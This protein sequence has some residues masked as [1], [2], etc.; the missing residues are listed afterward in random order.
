MLNDLGALA[1]AQRLFSSE[2][3]S[4][5]FTRLLLLDRIDL[6]LE[7]LVVNDSEFLRLFPE[8]LGKIAKRR[9]GVR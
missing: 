8:E 4:E 6:T 9:V 3:N 2:K 7:Y 1:T 5:G